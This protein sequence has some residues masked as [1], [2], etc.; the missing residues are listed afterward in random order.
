VANSHQREALPRQPHGPGCHCRE[1]RHKGQAARQVRG[2]AGTFRT[3]NLQA[4][5]VVEEGGISADVPPSNESQLV[6]AHSLRATWDDI[7][8][9]YRC[10]VAVEAKHWCSIIQSHVI[11]LDV[12][13]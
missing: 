10:C 13:I 4:S 7:H 5:L 8:A 6:N 12:E 11:D 2:Q 1:R 3:K 9:D